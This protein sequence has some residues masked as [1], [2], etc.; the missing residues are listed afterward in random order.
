MLSNELNAQTVHG[1]IIN[2][3]YRVI[4]QRDEHNRINVFPV[5]DGDTGDNMASVCSAIIECAEVKENLTLTV[6]SIAQAAIIGSRGNSGIL[7]T[8]FFVGLTNTSLLPKF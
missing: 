2:G 7:F 1:A 6:E 3:C 5:A 8:H 4:E